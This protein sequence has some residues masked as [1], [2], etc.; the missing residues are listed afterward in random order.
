MQRM[1]TSHEFALWDF[2]IFKIYMDDNNSTID[3]ILIIIYFFQTAD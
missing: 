3:N 1:H 2:F